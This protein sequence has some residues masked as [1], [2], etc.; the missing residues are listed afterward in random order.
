MALTISAAATITR[1]DPGRHCSIA[2][3]PLSV[4][5]RHVLLITLF[6]PPSDGCRIRQACQGTAR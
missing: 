5:R 3:L 6:H 1:A 4:G 2:A